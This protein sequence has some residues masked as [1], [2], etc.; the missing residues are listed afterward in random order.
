MK[1]LYKSPQ[2]IKYREAH[3]VAGWCDTPVGRHVEN[4][5]L[6]GKSVNLLLIRGNC[7]KVTDPLGRCS[8][9]LES[10]EDLS[11][12][13]KDDK[14]NP[15]HCPYILQLMKTEPQYMFPKH[16]SRNRVG[17]IQYPINLCKYRCGHYATGQGQHRICISG[18]L[19]LHL[20]RVRLSYALHKDCTSC[21]VSRA[22]VGLYTF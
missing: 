14:A 6:I 11:C 5:S 15:K 9:D 17:N 10:T 20:P 22:A 3:L 4:F 8:L 12:H 2:L 16:N 21:E 7:H 1:I 19:G 13:S 18:R